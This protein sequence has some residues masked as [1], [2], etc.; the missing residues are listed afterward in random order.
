MPT[1]GNSWKMDVN[2]ATKKYLLM[3]KYAGVPS[4]LMRTN[5]NMPVEYFK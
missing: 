5:P 2:A 1:I 3:L 4:V